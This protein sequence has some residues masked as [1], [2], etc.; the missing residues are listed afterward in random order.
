MTQSVKNLM[1][2]NDVDRFKINPS[3]S[4]YCIFKFE[5]SRILYQVNIHYDS[6]SA[7]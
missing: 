3:H 6:I 7:L 4:T 2:G 5:F 1:L